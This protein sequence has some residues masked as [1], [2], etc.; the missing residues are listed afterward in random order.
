MNMK[1]YLKTDEEQ[2]FLSNLALWSIVFLSSYLHDF[3]KYLECG[4]VYS[5][6]IFFCYVIWGGEKGQKGREKDKKE[7]KGR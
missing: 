3:F 7:E 6:S 4:R 1:S 5:K 2:A